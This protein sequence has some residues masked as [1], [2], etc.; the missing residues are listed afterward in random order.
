MSPLAKKGLRRN[1][2]VDRLTAQLAG[3]LAE[4]QQ[5]AGGMVYHLNTP[6][7]IDDD[8]P[9]K[10]RL[11][12]RLLLANQQANFPRLERKICFLMLRVKYQEKINRGDEQQDGG[13][14]NIDHFSQSNAVEI[15]GEV[16]DGDNTDHT[17]CVI[18]DGRFAAQRDP[19]AAFANGG[20]GFP[21]STAWLSPPTSRV[22]TH[23][24]W[25]E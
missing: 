11:H 25:T 15:A 6:L 8:H 21:S 22:P 19:E 4:P 14:K 13:D 3:G 20:D 1:D 24:G 16:A 9:L 17:P 7:A 2:A 23:S 12:H 18:N 10:D 5:A